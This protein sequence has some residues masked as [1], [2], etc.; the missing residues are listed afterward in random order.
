MLDSKIAMISPMST[1]KAVPLPTEAKTM[2]QVPPN[3]AVTQTI[4]VTA[5][6][7]AWRISAFCIEQARDL[8]RTVERAKELGE[9]A[10]TGRKTEHFSGRKY[11]IKSN[12]PNAR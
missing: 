11:L 1:W 4:P 3:S 7:V 5:T 12:W 8:S 9:Q 10:V 6:N 2:V